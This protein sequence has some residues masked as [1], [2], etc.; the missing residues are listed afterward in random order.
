MVNLDN[1]LEKIGD[2]AEESLINMERGYLFNQMTQLSTEGI[3]YAVEKTNPFLILIVDEETFKKLVHV[4]PRIATLYK[5]MYVFFKIRAIYMPGEEFDQNTKALIRVS[6]VGLGDSF[7]TWHML[8]EFAKKML[9]L[10][11]AGKLNANDEKEIHIWRLESAMYHIKEQVRIEE[12]A[13]E[14]AVKDPKNAQLVQEVKQSPKKRPSLDDKARELLRNSTR[15]EVK[16]LIYKYKL[17]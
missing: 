13:A 10:Q 2:K 5:E 14:L 6:K 4:E 8:S 3:A 11:R 17:K 12:R 7:A 9:A 15:D 16:H 1:S